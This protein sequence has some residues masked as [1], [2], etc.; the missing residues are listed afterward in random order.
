MAAADAA[1]AAAAA[2]LVAAQEA[3]DDDDVSDEV[4]LTG[5]SDAGSAASQP[6]GA[7]ADRLRALRAP[8]RPR[9]RPRAGTRRPD[10]VRGVAR[11]RARGNR[12]VGGRFSTSL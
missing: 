7:E 9:R 8:E 2:A 10:V 3:A 6:S 4:I 5:E 11:A 1:D 12:M